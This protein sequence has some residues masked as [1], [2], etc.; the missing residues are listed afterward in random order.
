MNAPAGTSLR[1]T[2]RAPSFDVATLAYKRDRNFYLLIT[3]LAWLGIIMGF[4]IDIRQDAAKGALPYPFIINFH[5]LVFFGWLVLFTVQVLLIRTRR[6]AMHRKLGMAMVFVAA[7]M[8]VLGPWAALSIAHRDLI[9]S[10]KSPEFLIILLFDILAF[11]GLTTAGILC[12]RAPAAHKCL[13]FLGTLY[14]ADA[15]FGRWVSHSSHYLQAWMHS[16]AFSFWAGFYGGSNLLMIALGAYDVATRRRLH[17]AYILGM[18]W[19]LGNQI[20]AT[21]L[22]FQPTSWVETARKMVAAWPW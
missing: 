13:M 16:G 17:I 4:E 21:A 5:A 10:N 1:P 22:Y 19:V 18:A 6:L 11:A 3:A 20:T 14:I 7:T 12:R 2:M 15:G 9:R 8:V